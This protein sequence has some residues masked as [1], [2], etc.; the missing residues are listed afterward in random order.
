VD[1]LGLIPAVT[2][3]GAAADDGTAAPRVHGQRA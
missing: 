3:T 2:V 1:T